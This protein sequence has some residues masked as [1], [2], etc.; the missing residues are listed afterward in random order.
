MV[1]ENLATGIMTPEEA[2]SGWLHS[3]HHCANLMEPRFTQM[4]VAFAVNERDE[5]GVYWTQEFG[6]PPR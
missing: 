4:G 5:A 1:G 3:P 2:V 6:R